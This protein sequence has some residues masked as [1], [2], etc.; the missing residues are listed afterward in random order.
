MFVWVWKAPVE[1]EAFDEE[2]HDSL[3]LG[4]EQWDLLWQEPQRKMNVVGEM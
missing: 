4:V 2:D 3:T 1:K